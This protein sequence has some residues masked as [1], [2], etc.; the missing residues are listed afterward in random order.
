[1]SYGLTAPQAALLRF[2]QGYQLAHG[3]VS[4]T[5]RECADGLAARSKSTAQRLLVELE[6]RGAIRRLPRR[7]R[8]IEV[9]TRL[10]IPSID[11]APLYAV[12]LPAGQ[13]GP[14]FSSQQQDRSH[15]A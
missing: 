14:T 15:A 8:A 12:P 7:E 11:G 9:I 2:V 1:M 13:G 6:R 10:A 4:P 3:G 5:V